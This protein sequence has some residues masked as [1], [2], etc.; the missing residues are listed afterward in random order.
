[1]YKLFLRLFFVFISFQI[2]SSAFAQNPAKSTSEFNVGWYQYF[3]NAKL[4]KKYFFYFDGAYRAFDFYK[5]TQLISFRPG[6]GYQLSSSNQLLAGY[7]YFGSYA[8]QNTD[9]FFRNEH[10][11]FQQF[12]TSSSEGRVNISHR[13]RAEERFI[14]N[15]TKRENYNFTLRLRY[16]FNLQIPLWG[17]EL[18]P[19]RPYLIL[20]DEFFVNF[21]SG[22]VLNYFDQ[23]RLILGLG[24]KFNSKY[25]LQIHYINVF[26]QRASGV[27]FEKIHTLRV[28]FFHQLDWSR[29]TE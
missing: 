18:K 11:F 4:S 23:N 25:N 13:L 28:A 10:R 24:Y 3:L 2:S 5:A 7:A 6:L 19:H 22:V 17:K 1:M 16:Q 12:Q 20:A 27:N 9:G 15:S 26:I 8:Y 14:Q 29:K 21:G